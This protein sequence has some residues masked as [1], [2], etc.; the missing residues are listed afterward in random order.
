[1]N[2]SLTPELAGFV[3]E[4][5]ESGMYH[6]ASEVVREGLRLLRERRQDRQVRLEELRR[7]IA[8]GLE[9]LDRGEGAPLDIEAIKAEGRRRLA[10]R[11]HPEPREAVDG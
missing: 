3:K 5:V 7:Q 6:S 10:E 11:Q 8:I 4:Q 1:M 9:Q 2:V